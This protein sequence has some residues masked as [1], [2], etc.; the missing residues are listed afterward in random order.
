MKEWPGSRSAEAGI[1][2]DQPSRA[3]SSLGAEIPFEDNWKSTKMEAQHGGGGALFRLRR[4]KGRGEIS[5]D[6][7]ERRG[8]M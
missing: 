8:V 1:E 2:G 5:I 3:D 4:R 6:A 7:D